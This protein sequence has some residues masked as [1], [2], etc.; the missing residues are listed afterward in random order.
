VK[1]VRG[2]RAGGKNQENQILRVST[3][4]REPFKSISS[5][6]PTGLPSSQVE[7]P[8]RLLSTW[9]VLPIPR[10][11]KRPHALT[12][13]KTT[14]QSVLEIIGALAGASPLLLDT[15]PWTEIAPLRDQ[16]G[17][18][19]IVP[20]GATEQ[21]GPHLPISCDT[22]I[23]TATCW[24]AS[25]K[26]GVPVAPAIPCSVSSGHT[27]KWPGTFSLGHE[28]FV[29]CIRDYAAWAAATGWKRL[30]FIN[31]HFGNDASL[32]VAIEQI[33]TRHLGDLLAG[34]RNTY[35]LTPEIWSAFTADAADLHANKA[36][37]DLLLHLT[38]GLVRT[39]KLAAADD[40]DRTRDSI[41]SYPVAQ[42]SLNGVTGFPSR[43]TAEDGATLFEQM[44]TALANLVEQAKTDTPPLSPDH[45]SDVHLPK[46]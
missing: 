41:F 22:I 28:T 1:R 31:A 14:D 23:A 2:K 35:A 3:P 20:V 4:L 38:P 32:R 36:E 10:T 46:I 12:V 17:G 40:P 6:P 33:R 43:A 37:T 16:N 42:T 34:V 8:F 45:W 7:R 25:A 13:I 5:F 44:G 9:A 15:L 21:H 24:F 19:L 39:G 18:L 26:T 29:A 27:A 30:L 11:G